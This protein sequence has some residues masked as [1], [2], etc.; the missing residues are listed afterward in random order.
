MFHGMKTTLLNKTAKE[1]GGDS[2]ENTCVEE[3]KLKNNH[4]YKKDFKY[5][6]KNPYHD[7]LIEF[8]EFVM[9][10]DEAESHSGKWNQ[11]VFK[12][13]A[14]LCVE[15]GTGYGHFML[16]YCEKNPNVNFI[17]MDFRFKRS[18]N[19]AK[20][21]D[22]HPHKNFKYLRAR[23]ERIQF[24]F[25]EGEVEKLFYFFPDPWPK[26]RHHKKRLFQQPFLEAAYKVL[27]P[28]GNLFVKTDHEGYA[29]WMVEY[30]NKPEAL[31]LFDVKLQTLD[32]YN[33][34]QDHY[35]ASFQT[36]FEKI[37]LKK[38]EPI[39]AFELVSRKS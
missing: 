21:L 2:S 4:L 10:D 16:D 11:G 26:K 34:A 33:E 28:G 12:R 13:N 23:G 17:G 7:K 32:L 19:L 8:D 6:H 39:K 15:I 29:D 30:M 9:R 37:F 1:S 31:E 27:R 14:P 25:E 22:A 36:K 18:Y 20:K 3:K 5:S 24:M 38:N 35:L